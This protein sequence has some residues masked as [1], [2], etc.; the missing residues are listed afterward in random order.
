MLKPQ[1][2]FALIAAIP[3]DAL[4]SGGSITGRVTSAADAGSEPLAGT[5]VLVAGTVRGTTTD[6][7]GR[8]NISNLNA[9]RYT[10]HFSLVGYQRETRN[11][12]VVEEGKETRL[13]ITMTQR[14]IQAEA[15]VVTAARRAQ[16]LEDV[17]ASVSVMDAERIRSRNSLTIDD[18]LR[19]VPG[20]NMTGTQVNIRGSSGYSLGAG[21][22]VLMLLDGVP[23]ITGD[24]GELIF[25]AI[26]AGEIDRIEVVKGAGSALYGSNALGGV[27]NVITKPIP[28]SPSTTVRTYAGFYM[29]PSFDQWKW[30]DR[31][32]FFNGQ[33]VTLTRK[34]HDF[35]LSFH[36]ARQLDDGYRQNDYRRRYNLFMKLR[37]EFSASSALTLNVGMLYQ[38]SGQFLYW[39]SLDS[40]LIPPPRHEDDNL[41]S[42]RFYLNAIYSRVL[43]DD[44]LI[45]G[46]ALWY[47][48]DWGFQMTGDA[49]RTESMVDGIRAEVSS[50]L[51]LGG[52]H[53]L[54][55][56]LDGN[57]D[58]I[59]G[60][61][62]G[63]RTIGGV[64]LF[65]Q[66]EIRLIEEVTLT[67]GGRCDFQSAGLARE[68]VEVNP[69][70]A[71]V[72]RPWEETAIR[73]SYG[74][75]FRVPSVAEAFIAAGS[76]PVTGVPNTDLKPE[77]SSS[78]EAGIGQTL[79]ETGMLD[80]AAFE[81]DFENLIEPGLTV[82]G[83]DLVIQ[84]RNVTKA[85]IRGFETSGTLSL[86]GSGLMIRLGYTY[87][88]PEDR[89]KNDLL[90]Y[91]PRHI[92]YTEALARVGWITAGI[93]FRY[94]SRVDRIDD[95]LVETGVVPDGD[96]RQ[97]I[98]VVDAR[99]GADIPVGAA[100]LTTSL[101]VRNALQH[102]YVELIGNLM[103]PRSVSLV[104]EVRL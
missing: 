30:S 25:E 66:G 12:V 65:G 58:R 45:T 52:L 39:R 91:R 50:T 40:A 86:F 63:H 83:Q 85:R 44:L 94:V 72:Y 1:I 43:S 59:G 14:T 20:V 88:Y 102:N 35:G 70:A 4:A 75:G 68:R 15:I 60:D 36:L 5:T 31:T 82:V 13:E 81:S 3:T 28:E 54:T 47:H 9:G 57:V 96:E 98:F 27:I 61:M 53:T 103:P 101:T 56:G 2:L 84:W 76:G 22:R 46:K 42:T 29:N 10:L 97:E 51:V 74:R 8:F 90:K 26:P 48:T 89:T 7:E 37:Q 16:S 99:L 49:G 73:C 23:F 92:L 104:L 79:G 24:T 78:F 18:A 67:A 38:Y 41:K 6:A 62:L 55:F 34:L 17:P 80:L 95:E 19:Y 21:S 77:R 11:D 32:R 93:D 64:A 87:V 71:L 33:S 69:K 100:V